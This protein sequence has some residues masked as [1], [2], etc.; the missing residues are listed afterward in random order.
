VQGREICLHSRQT[1][2]GALNNEARIKTSLNMEGVVATPITTNNNRVREG[3][4]QDTFH[5]KQRQIPAKRTENQ[6][7]SCNSLNMAGP[8]VSTKRKCRTRQL[9]LQVIKKVGYDR[10]IYTLH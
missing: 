8:A 10:I 2:S 1:L 7:T 4:T 3:T 9:R 5:N 6:L